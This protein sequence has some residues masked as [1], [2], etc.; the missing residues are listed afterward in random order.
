M[1]TETWTQWVREIKV[2]LSQEQ[3]VLD[4]DISKFES[5]FVLLENNHDNK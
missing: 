2:F 5:H 3:I 4:A 1:K